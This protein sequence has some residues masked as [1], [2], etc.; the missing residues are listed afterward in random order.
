MITAPT[1]I[2]LDGLYSGRMADLRV[3]ELEI[4]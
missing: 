1:F 3:A 4:Q 2:D